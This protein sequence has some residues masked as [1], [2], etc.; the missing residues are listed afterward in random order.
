MQNFIKYFNEQNQEFSNEVTNLLESFDLK[1]VAKL[2]NKVT[3]KEFYNICT[4]IALKDEI[5]PS[6]EM[7]KQTLSNIKAAV[8]YNSGY[9]FKDNDEFLVFITGHSKNEIHFINLTQKEDIEKTKS[10]GKIST[11]V[12]STVISVAIKFMKFNNS[13]IFD[14][15][16]PEDRINLYVKILDKV[17]KKHLNTWELIEKKKINNSVVLRYKNHFSMFKQKLKLD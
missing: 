15:Y 13:K 17:I 14:I 8:D 5:D 6:D 10:L 1:N 11:K 9:K 7:R 16:V 3:P 2:S 12:F 4:A